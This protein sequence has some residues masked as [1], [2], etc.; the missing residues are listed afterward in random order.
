MASQRITVAKFGGVSAGV[1][2][3]R[4]RDWN[5]ARHPASADEWSSDQWPPE[6]RLQVDAFA[7]RLRANAV[8]PPVLAYV[9]WSD[10][11]SMGDLFVRWLAPP[12]GPPPVVLYGDRFEVYGYAL[13]DDGRLIRHLAAAGPQQFP[14]SD[15]YVSRLHETIE[16]WRDLT[17]EAA[18]VVLREVVGGLVTDEEGD[19]SLR[20]VPEWL[21]GP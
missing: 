17:R 2:M 7:D 14:E 21:A 10:L 6:V 4:L 18:I 15:Q 8:G 9:E 11:W 3:R 12:G 13:P 5:I 19:E 1:V 16:A 20:V